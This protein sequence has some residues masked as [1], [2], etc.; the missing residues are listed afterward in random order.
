MP[1]LLICGHELWGKMQAIPTGARLSPANWIAIA[2]A[3]GAVVGSLVTASLGYF[4]RV[5]ELDVRM[6]EL[7]IEIL[8]AAP[9]NEI[10]AIRGWAMDVIEEK[11]GF[12]FTEAQRAVLL[13]LPLPSR[14]D[15]LVREI[16]DAARS[17]VPELSEEEHQR[18]KLEIA[19]IIED[20]TAQVARG[21]I[22]QTEFSQLLSARQKELELQFQS[23]LQ[24]RE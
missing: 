21:E 10:G 22:S 13:E 2:G 7:G 14:F 6:V 17:L 15:D 1:D 16:D 9:S 3:A 8:Q 24:S 11:S 18:F 4:G 20:L 19:K 5:R 12:P 23:L